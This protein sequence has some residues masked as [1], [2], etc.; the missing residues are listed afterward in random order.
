MH[1]PL[2][3]DQPRSAYARE[4]APRA[5]AHAET[6]GGIF[7]E[8]RRGVERHGGP[9]SI[10]FLEGIFALRIQSHRTPIG[11]QA[12][13]RTVRQRIIHVGH[14]VVARV[15]PVLIHTLER[16]VHDAV[17]HESIHEMIVMN[18]F[19]IRQLHVAEQIVLRGRLVFHRILPHLVAH[20]LRSH[21]DH[22]G[23]I[24]A[25][26]IV[27]TVTETSL[28][29]P[30]ICDV[31]FRCQAYSKPVLLIGVLRILQ[32]SQRIGYPQFVHV[33]QR[34]RELRSVVGIAVAHQERSFD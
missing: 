1:E 20:N 24:M 12:V 5:A 30:V 11:I 27:E 22:R 2:A 3:C 28:Y 17:T 23:E 33:V 19:A 26:G 15:V 16:G 6:S 18:Q 10:T 32:Q 21:A 25:F 14:L 9:Q 7:A 34:I 13:Y 8:T 4:R 29:H 31:P